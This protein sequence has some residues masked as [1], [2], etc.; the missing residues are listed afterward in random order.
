MQGFLGEKIGEGMSSDVH[1]WAA[2]QAVKLFKAGVPRWIV[3]HEAR[4]TRAAFAA[5]LPAPKVFGDVAL[6][7]RFGIVLSQLDG[8][9]LLHLSRTGAMTA[10]QV[11][12]LLAT[13][14]MTVHK[15]PRRRRC[16]CCRSCMEGKICGRCLIADWEGRRRRQRSRPR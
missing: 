13:L 11:G 14:A 12:T 4:M 16:C 10:Q 2:G 15:T 7:G 9:T 5:G 3:R 6:E 8:P 1:A